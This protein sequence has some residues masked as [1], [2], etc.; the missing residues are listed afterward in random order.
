M[1]LTI[2]KYKLSKQQHT[3]TLDYTLGENENLFTDLYAYDLQEFFSPIGMRFVKQEMVW[4]LS[5]Q[6]HLIN[7]INRSYLSGLGPGT[8]YPQDK[9]KAGLELVVYLWQ[10]KIKRVK[11]LVY[12]FLVNSVRKQHIE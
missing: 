7:M 9:C 6:A 8:L 3:I 5:N 4:L 2:S 11:Y 10:K 1:T 12:I